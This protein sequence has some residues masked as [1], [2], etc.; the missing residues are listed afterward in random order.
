MPK[1]GRTRNTGAIS[2]TLLHVSTLDIS[3]KVPADAVAVT[4]AFSVEPP[5]GKVVFFETRYQRR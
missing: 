3:H 1:T 5:D 2:G 4:M